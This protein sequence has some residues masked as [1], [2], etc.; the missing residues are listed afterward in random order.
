MDFRVNDIEAARLFYEL[1]Y[2]WV[3]LLKGDDAL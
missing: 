2:L 1:E 3:V